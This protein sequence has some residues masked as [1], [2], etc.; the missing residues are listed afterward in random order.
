MY[1][2]LKAC[3]LILIVTWFAGLFYIVRLWI[4]QTEAALNPSSSSQARISLLKVMSY[5]LWYVITWPSAVLTIGLG[6]WLLLMSDYWGKNWMYVKL[7]FVAL[8]MGYHGICHYLFVSLQRNRYVWRPL[9]LRLWNEAATLLL[10][11]LVLCAVLKEAFSWTYA[12]ALWI[13]LG[14]LFLGAIRLY[15]KFQKKPK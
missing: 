13:A 12:I 1:L 3:H 14:T 9:A 4:Y 8:L 2:Y 10:I 6:L 11:T 7:I 15:H 5:R